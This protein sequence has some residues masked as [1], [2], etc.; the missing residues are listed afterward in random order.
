MPELTISYPDITDP[1]VQN[2]IV[3]YAAPVGVFWT[4]LNF[5]QVG[6]GK[7]KFYSNKRGSFLLGMTTVATSS[8]ISQSILSIGLFPYFKSV[9]FF[10]PLEKKEVIR[11][12]V[13]TTL[14]YSTLGMSLCQSA[15]PSSVIT[16]GAFAKGRIFPYS[17]SGAIPSTSA[18]ATPNQRAK[19][20]KY[21]KIF[22][23]HHCGSRQLFGKKNFIADHMPPTKNANEM[24]KARWRRWLGMEV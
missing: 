19:I 10:K 8:V 12:S 23:C 16:I 24:N 9:D 20:Q 15:L 22:G 5:F 14:I 18:V 3:M 13:V 6:F 4:V 7:M 21:G 17:L 2:Q 11:L 1:N